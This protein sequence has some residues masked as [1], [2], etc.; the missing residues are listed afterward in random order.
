[1]SRVLSLCRTYSQH[2]SD[3]TRIIQETLSLQKK[4][5]KN[6]LSILLK[7]T[8]LLLG[9]LAF[10]PGGVSKSMADSRLKGPWLRL[11]HLWVGKLLHRHLCP[12]CIALDLAVQFKL[13]A[14]IR[15]W[16]QI[17]VQDQLGPSGP[18][19]TRWVDDQQGSSLSS[20]PTFSSLNLHYKHWPCVMSC[21]V[22][23]SDKY[24]AQTFML[25]K[26]TRVQILDET[27][28]IFT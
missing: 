20:F 9:P 6:G 21:L 8:W 10:V 22:G 1:M 17:W 27:D 14:G 3:L 23:G 24:I 13:W 25:S 5:W 19:C 18:H 28:C 11:G 15:A 2:I 16:T 26:A 7:L 4:S 12:P